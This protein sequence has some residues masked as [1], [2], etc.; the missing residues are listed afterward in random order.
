M[1]TSWWSRKKNSMSLELEIGRIKSIQSA[2][3]TS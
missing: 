1:D 3:Y 2:I